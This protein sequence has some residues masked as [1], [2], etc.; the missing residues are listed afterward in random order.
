ML[1]NKTPVRYNKT[2][3]PYY[4]QG[5]RLS[6]ARCLALNE[7]LIVSEVKIRAASTNK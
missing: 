5:K 7:F 3:Y 6:L 4:T 2:N 1:P